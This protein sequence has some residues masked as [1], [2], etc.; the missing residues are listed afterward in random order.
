M[1]RHHGGSDELITNINVTPLVDIILVLLIIFMVATEVIHE[2]ERANVIQVNLPAAASGE[3]LISAGLLNL[4]IDAK[5]QLYING[6]VGDRAAVK[7]AIEKTRTQGIVAQALITAD[8][9]TTHGAVVSLMDF[10]RIAGV[11]EIAI[12]TQKQAIE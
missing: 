2:T 6:E 10:L 7:S 12:N 11:T 4:V 5:G 8:Q 9:N 1:M 3:R